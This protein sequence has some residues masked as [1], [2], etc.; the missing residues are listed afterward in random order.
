MLG[1]TN[2][3][4]REF[5]RRSGSKAKD[6]KE[7][8]K[9]R[10]KKRLKVGNN[11]GQLRIS[12]ATL[13]GARKPPGPKILSHNNNKQILAQAALRAQ[14]EV[15]LECIAGHCYYPLSLLFS[16]PSFAFDPLQRNSRG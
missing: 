16:F 14:P 1:E 3:Q 7:K 2:F 13:G 6:G 12:T 5:P 8:K 11:N 9:K 4:P 15:A 10:E